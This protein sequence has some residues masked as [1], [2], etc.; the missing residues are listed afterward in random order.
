MGDDAVLS[1][2]RLETGTERILSEAQPQV[3]RMTWGEELWRD[4]HGPWFLA[5]VAGRWGERQKQGLAGRQDWP[6]LRPLHEVRTW[7]PLLKS[8]I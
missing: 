5:E 8:R 1:Q 7:C 4:K 2:G 6:G 3:L